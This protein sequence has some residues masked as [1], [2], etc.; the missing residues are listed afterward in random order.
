MSPNDCQPV[1]DQEMKTIMNLDSLET[2]EQIEEFLLVTQLVAFGVAST[3]QE[4]Y[5]WLQKTLIKWRYHAQLKRLI[6][7]Q[8]DTGTVTHRPAR[9]NGFKRQYTD[10]DARLP[11][12]IDGHPVAGQ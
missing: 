3:K 5:D 6:K 2:L 12:R 11:A 4:R 10:A 8:R 1:H 7:Q 9:G